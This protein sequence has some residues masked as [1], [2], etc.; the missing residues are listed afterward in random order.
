MWNLSGVYELTAYFIQQTE[1]WYWSF[2]LRYS[3]A[4]WLKKK[5]VTSRFL[6]QGIWIKTIIDFD[7]STYRIVSLYYSPDS[8]RVLSLVQSRKLKP[9]FSKKW[10]KLE[11]NPAPKIQKINRIAECYTDS[12]VNS[13]GLFVKKFPFQF[14]VADRK[15]IHFLGLSINTLLDSVKWNILWNRVSQ[16]AEI[17]VAMLLQ[18]RWNL[19]HI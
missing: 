12:T 14:A 19:P 16:K 11:Y 17:L 5:I 7:Q 4:K 18:R 10:Q 9:L 13:F 6:R 3:L 1:I 15:W 2:H 8:I